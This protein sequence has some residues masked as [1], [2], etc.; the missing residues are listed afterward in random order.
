MPTREEEL[1]Q[2]RVAKLERLRA[3][4]IDPYPARYHRSHASAEAISAFEAWEK[5]QEGEAP[6]VS[7]GGRVTALRNMRKASFLD[8]RDGDGRIQ[9]YVRADRVSEAD[10]ETLKDVD[11]GDFLGA[12]GKL[13]RTRTGEITVEAASLTM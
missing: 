1:F 5:S 12:S 10:F 7:V 2:E 6:V 8:L 9:G 4:G 3:R 13:F 11:L